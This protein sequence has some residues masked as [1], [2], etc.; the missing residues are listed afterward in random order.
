MHMCLSAKKLPFTNLSALKLMCMGSHHQHMFLLTL[1]HLNIMAESLL[2]AVLHFLIF[3][4]F[5]W[6]TEEV[7]L[8]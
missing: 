1:L 7:L 5:L 3:I 2:N 8:V 4:F 6:E